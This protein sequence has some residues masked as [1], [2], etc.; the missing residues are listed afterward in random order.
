M[1]KKVSTNKRL[2]IHLTLSWKDNLKAVT[3]LPLP[4]LLMN[5]D[6]KDRGG[7]KKSIQYPGCSPAI[8][9]NST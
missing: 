9:R 7:R 3:Q 6:L 1:L 2:L 5:L 4:S 8:E